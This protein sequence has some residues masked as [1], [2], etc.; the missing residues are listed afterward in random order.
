[1][2]KKTLWP[3]EELP[4]IGFRGDQKITIKLYYYDTTDL[5]PSD[6]IV[7]FDHFRLPPDSYHEWDS[8]LGAP[9]NTGPLQLFALVD[10]GQTRFWHAV[11]E[12]HG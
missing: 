12:R 7:R 3:D 8:R 1:M 4:T 11:E 2:T 6:L 5:I 10:D 9:E